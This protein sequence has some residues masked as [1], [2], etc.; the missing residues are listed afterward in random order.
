MI[1]YPTRESLQLIGAIGIL[2]CIWLLSIGMA[3]PLFIYKT[4]HI[5]KLPEILH[6]YGYKVITF[7]VENWP[8]KEGRFYFSVFALCLQY[9]VPIIIVSAAYIRIYY[10]LKNR[11]PV[12]NVQ[13]AQR[14]DHRERRMKR[15]NILLISIAAIFGICWL[16][17]NLFLLYT[18][19]MEIRKSENLL[20]VYAICHLI[21]MSSACANPLLYG[22]LNENFRKEFKELL[23]CS[24]NTN[25]VNL[26]ATNL[27]S[28]RSNHRRRF[29]RLFK[30]SR[31]STTGNNEISQADTRLMEDG[32]GGR[33]TLMVTESMAITDNKF[34]TEITTLV[35]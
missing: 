30:K 2:V 24:R 16:P 20:I 27:G 18:D 10:K 4:V 35:G 26:N 7:C 23:C 9:L 22:Y 13:T 6:Q 5:Y 14:S 28:N 3:S 8:V 19:A 11:I 34:S 31:R 1:V 29:W 21:A 33:Q 17:L 32:T 25:N 12:L 15:T